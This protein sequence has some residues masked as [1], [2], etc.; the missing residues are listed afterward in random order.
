MAVGPSNFKLMDAVE[1]RL[2]SENEMGEGR[3][4]NVSHEIILVKVEK[5][6]NKTEKHPC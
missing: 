3:S 4:H 2:V 1:R 5:T 6:V